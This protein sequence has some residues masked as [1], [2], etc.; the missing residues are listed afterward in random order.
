[1][2]AMRVACSIELGERDRETLEKW[3][4][5]RSTAVRL[6]ERSKII[7]LAANG[8]QNRQIAEQ[9]G[10]DP[11]TVALWRCRFARSGIAGI[12]KDAPRGGRKPKKRQDVVRR[13]VKKTTQEKPKN[14]T[15][16]S[17]RTLACELGVN[18][19]LVH[20]VWRANGLKPHLVKTL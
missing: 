14:A 19:T 5:R 10:V 6:V 18:P 2:N 1:M 16:W 9:V 20:R 7:L 12:E 15:H 8:M 4:R 17:T 13:I 3:S 11:R